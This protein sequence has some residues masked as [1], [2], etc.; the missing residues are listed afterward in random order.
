L[1]LLL[2]PIAWIP[3]SA[4]LTNYKDLKSFD[5][6][7]ISAISG[8]FLGVMTMARFANFLGPRGTPKILW[9]L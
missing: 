7:N 2:S 9:F 4:G 1:K 6:Q 8:E 5:L 3:A